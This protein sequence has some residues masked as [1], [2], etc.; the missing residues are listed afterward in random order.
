MTNSV[1]N[2]IYDPTLFRENEEKKL[3][4]NLLLLLLLLDFD[5]INY[6]VSKYR[7]EHRRASTVS[8][9]MVITLTQQ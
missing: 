1:Q 7:Q 6:K 2:K 3:E 4:I 8:C 5:K 9:T